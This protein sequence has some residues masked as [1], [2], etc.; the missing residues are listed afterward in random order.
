MFDLLDKYLNVDDN[1]YI[2][3]KINIKI[4][5]INKNA[6]SHLFRINSVIMVKKTK[7]KR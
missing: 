5:E 3:K 2:D 7:N 6:L 4:E 1:D